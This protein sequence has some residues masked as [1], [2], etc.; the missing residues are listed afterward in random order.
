MKKILISLLS[1]L[2]LTAASVWAQTPQEIIARMD[3]EKSRFDKEGFSMVME[4]K[5]RDLN[6]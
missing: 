6:L 5:L 2:L 1:V 4:M 3:Q